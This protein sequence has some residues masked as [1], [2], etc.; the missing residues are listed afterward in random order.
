[1]NTH[2]DR[3]PVGTLARITGGFCPGDPPIRHPG[4]VASPQ[5]ASPQAEGTS[6]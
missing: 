6:A 1:V 5:V 3:L 4:L 2:D